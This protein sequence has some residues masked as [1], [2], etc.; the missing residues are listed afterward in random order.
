MG[1]GC[2]LL[3]VGEPLELLDGDLVRAGHSWMSFH[4]GHDG[5][6]GRL[7]LLDAKGG[8]RLGIGLRGRALSLGREAG[9]VVIPWDSALAEL[10]LQ[11]LVREDATFV[12]DLSTAGGTWVV[13]RAGE[14]LGSGS[15]IAVGER[16]LRVSTPPPRNARLV[17]LDADTR[18]FAAA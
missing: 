15:V 4:A 2:T 7:C 6:P 16:L 8:V 13:V 17:D 14:V 10:H 9:D 5:R 11:L 3:R 1:M 18:L 12:Q